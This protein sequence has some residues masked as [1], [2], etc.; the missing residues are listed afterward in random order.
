MQQAEVYS[1]A[2]LDNALR[3]QHDIDQAFEGEIRSRTIMFLNVPSAAVQCMH[4]CINDF[5][6][7]ASMRCEASAASEICCASIFVLSA[8]WCTC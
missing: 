7:P 1:R 3:T 4:A 6:Q 2:L 8:R 5:P